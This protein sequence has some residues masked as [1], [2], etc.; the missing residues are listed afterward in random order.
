MKLKH[1]I[2]ISVFIVIAFIT[3]NLS[4]DKRDLAGEF[5]ATEIRQIKIGMNLEDVQEILGQPYQITSLAGLHNLTCKRQKSQLEEEIN[6]NCD[7]RLL[8]NQKFSETDFCCEGNKD[9]LACKRV[10][11]VYTKR[12]KFSRHYP[13]LWIHLDSHFQVVSVFAKQYD[14]YLGFEDPCIYS[15]TT[16]NYFENE[17]LFERNFK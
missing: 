11:L 7:I 10:T 2:L 1:T 14:G 15:L 17:D 13:M 5:S 9:D 3:V 16:D 12:Q 8:V 6:P 4:M